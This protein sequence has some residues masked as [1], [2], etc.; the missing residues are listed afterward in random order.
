MAGTRGPGPFSWR[1]GWIPLTAAA[2]VSKA[3]GSH[4]NAKA[5]FPKAYRT[6]RPKVKLSAYKRKG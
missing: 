4:K 5:A 3:H 2:A 1:H 6:Q